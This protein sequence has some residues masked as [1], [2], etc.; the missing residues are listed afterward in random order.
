MQRT[1]RSSAPWGPRH[2]G[3]MDRGDGSLDRSAKPENAVV[4]YRLAMG[5]TAFVLAVAALVVGCAARASVERGAWSSD[6]QAAPARTACSP[7]SGCT[8][9]PRDPCVC[10]LQS[11]RDVEALS[12]EWAREHPPSPSGGC[13]DCLSEANPDLRAVCTGHRCRVLDVSASPLSACTTAADCVAI[14][15]GCCP[16]CGPNWRFLAVNERRQ[17]RLRA[18]LC[19]ADYQ[20]VTCPACA[21]P[22]QPHPAVSCV[23]G[24]C[25]VDRE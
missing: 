12:N 11:A 14:D 13:P 1:V 25:R 17:G 19:G 24:H 18:Q 10:G 4:V 23:A 15:S 21:S 7:E 6:K 20:T 2:L 8:L 5:K 3:R 22:P 9:Y 16:P